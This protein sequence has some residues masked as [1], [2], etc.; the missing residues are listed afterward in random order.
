VGETTYILRNVFCYVNW[1]LAA[2]VLLRA[3]SGDVPLP[4]VLISFAPGWNVEA[5]WNAFGLVTCYVY[6][7]Q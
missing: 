6:L 5:L 3:D 7:A 2:L 1:H 4:S